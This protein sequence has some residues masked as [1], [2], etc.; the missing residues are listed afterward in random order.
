MSDGNRHPNGY[1]NSL[2]D[3]PPAGGTPLRATSPVIEI[4][5]DLAAP[6]STFCCHDEVQCREPRTVFALLCVISPV[7]WNTPPRSRILL[8]SQPRHSR[9][10]G[11]DIHVAGTRLFS[12]QSIYN[13]SV[14]ELCPKRATQNSQV[15]L[16]EGCHSPESIRA[17]TEAASLRSSTFLD[18]PLRPIP[19]V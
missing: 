10:A 9:T 19:T 7:T 1:R 14:I 18:M 5:E 2:A 11:A 17:R 4:V 6:R 15:C 3:L 13:S 16:S 12:G 8:S